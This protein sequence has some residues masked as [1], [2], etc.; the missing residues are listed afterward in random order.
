MSVNDYLPISDYGYISD[1]HS[2]AL[3]SRD[4]SIDWACLPRFDSGSCFAR[5]LDWGKGGFCR[6]SPEQPYKSSRRYIDSTLVLE[7]TFENDQGKVRLTDCFTMKEG[8]EHSPHRQILRTVEGLRGSMTLKFECA[9]RFEYGAVKPW[10]RKYGGDQYIALGGN[11]GLLVSGNFCLGM[12]HRHNLEGKCNINKGERVYLSILHRPPEMLD[13]GIVEVP[14]ISELGQRLDETVDWWRAW[15]SQAGFESPYSDLAVRSALVLKGLCNAPTGAIAAAATTS[16]P[17][18]PGGS[19]NWDY[20]YA[21]V[22]DSCFA[23][24]SLAEIGF[25][26]EADGFRRFVER[27]AAGSADELQILFGIGGERRFT[28]Q[29]LTELEGYRGAKPVRIGNAAEKQVQLD[30]YGELLNLAWLWYSRG[31]SPDADYWEFLT[32]TVE[33]VAEIWRKPDRGIWEMRGK[34]RHFVHSKVMCWAALN[35]GIEIAQ[36]LEWHAPADRWKKARDDV[37]MA[38]EKEG[39]DDKRGIF[40]QAF[41]RHEPD[42]ALLLIPT[43]GFVDYTDERMVRTTNAIQEQLDRDGLLRRYPEGNDELSGREGVFLACSFWLVNCLARQGRLEEA[44]KVFRRAAGTAN[45]LGLFSEE[46]D[47]E[48]QEM[49][50]NFPQGLTHL[51]LIT[52]TIALSEI[53]RRA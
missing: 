33:T 16:L 15:S 4:G 24:K 31:H 51:S 34:P 50:G 13:E 9:P 26:K 44:H 21:W 39:Y 52:A 32:G 23:V 47:V 43:V 1:C 41:D 8:G 45:E 48:R 38:V 46:Y 42:A 19:R 17:E 10:I 29:D 37:R 35:Y 22:R 28:E 5:I 40:V 27:S 6:I 49:L 3:V 7:T 30:V 53:E 20:R 12:K 18:T 14:S 36:R 25:E 11:S 2:C